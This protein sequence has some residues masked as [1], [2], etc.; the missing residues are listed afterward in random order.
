MNDLV[1]M[2]IEIYHQNFPY[3]ITIGCRHEW[4]GLYANWKSIIKIF[5]IILISVPN[6]FPFQLWYKC[7]DDSDIQTR[8]CPLWRAAACRPDLRN[9]LASACSYCHCFSLLSSWHGQFMS[10]FS[11]QNQ[12]WSQRLSFKNDP[13][14][15]QLEKVVYLDE[16]SW[17]HTKLIKP[18]FRWPS[19]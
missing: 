11:F 19:G 3:Y 16:N 13:R 17:T 6:L 15:Q 1:Y 5:L 7:Q 10:H 12:D 2:Q 8:F 18:S 9:A 4:F 14:R